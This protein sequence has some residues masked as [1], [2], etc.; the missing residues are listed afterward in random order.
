MM[1]AQNAPYQ[2]EKLEKKWEVT[3]LN[4]P[5]SV[6]PVPEKGI[7]YVSN[8]GINNPTEKEGKGFI[9][10]LSMDGKIKTL[11][12]CDN[13]NSPKG[14][15]ISGDKL[16]VSEVDR[17][18]EIDLK[19]GKKLNDFPVDGAV[20]LNDI[21]AGPDGSLYISD[22]R[23]GTIHKLKD[24]K[25][26]VFIKSDDFPNPNGVVFKKE[27]L[28]LGTGKKIVKIDPA[29]KEVKDYMLNTGGVDG[30]AVVDQG[31]VIFSDWPGTV[32]IMKKG[33]EKELLLDTS[34]LENAKTADFGYIAEKKLV[35]IPTFFTNSVVCYKL[36]IE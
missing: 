33:E 25:V 29:T 21:A 4:V 12:W 7:L 32:H 22:S 3:G 34:M 27:K 36:K 23:T 15:A 16:Y 13:L 9:S 17:I 8:I 19:T 20:F 10:I 30:L 6:L 24:G 11:K 14:M 1:F 2:S 5:E 28:L 26:K 18:A 35:Y 31:I